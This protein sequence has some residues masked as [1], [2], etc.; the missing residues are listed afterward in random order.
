M[1]GRD[2]VEIVPGRIAALLQA[3]VVEAPPEH[4]F[5]EGCLVDPL[6]DAGHQFFDRRH[7]FGAALDP[8]AVLSRIGD[9]HMVFDEGRRQSPTCKVDHPGTVAD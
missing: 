5:A 2:R 6:R 9:M 4:P 7:G 8:I 3:V 1:S